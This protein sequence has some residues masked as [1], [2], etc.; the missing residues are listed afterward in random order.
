MTC[1][2]WRVQLSSFITRQS[3]PRDT[4]TAMNGYFGHVHVN[5]FAQSYCYIELG[6]PG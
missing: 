6:A 2:A 5:Y 1:S 3:G 4:M